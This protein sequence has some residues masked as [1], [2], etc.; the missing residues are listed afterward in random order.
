MDVTYTYLMNLLSINIIIVGLPACLRFCW[1]DVYFHQEKLGHW[2]L[3]YTNILIYDGTKSQKVSM[4]T[5]NYL[6]TYILHI[7]IRKEGGTLKY[8]QV[9]QISDF[10]RIFI[11]QSSGNKFVI[12]KVNLLKDH[13]FLSCVHICTLYLQLNTTPVLYKDETLY[14]A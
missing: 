10:R 8:T 4:H 12:I 13:V 3:L 1:N 9:G 7:L 5:W 6:F 2:V 11:R 14:V